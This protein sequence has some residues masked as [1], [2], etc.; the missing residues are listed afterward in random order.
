LGQFGVGESNFRFSDHLKSNMSLRQR[1]GGFL[2]K[3]KQ[4]DAYA[5][6][7]EDFRIKTATG[8]S[9]TSH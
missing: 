8:A 6:P 4:Y 5:K 9:G 1:E 3:F 2:S 7:L